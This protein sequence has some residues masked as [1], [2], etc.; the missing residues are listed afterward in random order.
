MEIVFAKKIKIYLT[1]KKLYDILYEYVRK[2]KQSSTLTLAQ[3]AT[4]VY[5]SRHTAK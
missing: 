3:T 5:I 4:W 2:R 1:V